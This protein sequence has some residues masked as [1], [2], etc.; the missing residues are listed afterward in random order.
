MAV[1]VRPNAKL[2]KEA[3]L[4]I[5]QTGGMCV[6][7]YMQTSDEHI[8][9]AGDCIE[10]SNLITG[11]KIHA[12]YGDLAN[13][14]GRVAGE[15]AVLGNTVSFP[16]SIQ[17]G[18]CKIFDFAAGSTGLNERAARA[19]GFDIL[20]VMNASPDKPGFM[21]GKL[22]ITKLVVEKE[23]GRILGAQ[24]VGPGNV[25][26]QIAQWALAITGKLGVEDIVNADLPYAPPFSLAI[27]H[28]IATAHLMQNKM[29]GRLKGIPAARGSGK[30]RAGEKIFLLDARGPDEYRGNAPRHRRNLDSPGRAAQAPGGTAR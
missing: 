20:T 18:I 14:E 17:T 30:Q 3:G 8:Y 7:Q 27:D 1:G 15:N 6:N 19:A 2:A 26:K 4:E 11:K 12:P 9:A 23:S 28:F 29:K 5:G 10:I 22:L 13:L 21:N 16:G 25:A 24:C